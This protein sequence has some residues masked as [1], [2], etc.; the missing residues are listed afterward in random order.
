MTERQSTSLVGGLGGGTHRGSPAVLEQRD[1]SEGIPEGTV[2]EGDAVSRLLPCLLPMYVVHRGGDDP[3]E[4]I[5]VVKHC[6]AQVDRGCARGSGFTLDRSL[7][8]SEWGV[9]T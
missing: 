9:P 2:D 6:A 1:G 7:S 4:G 3:L 5:G 8:G